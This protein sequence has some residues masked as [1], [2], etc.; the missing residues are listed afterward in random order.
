LVMI[1]DMSWTGD[2]SRQDLELAQL[3]REA[4]AKASLI[5]TKGHL[6]GPRL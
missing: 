4:T 6:K 1:N 2:L 3:T 5:M